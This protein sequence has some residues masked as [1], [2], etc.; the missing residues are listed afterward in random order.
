M[1]FFKK[2]DFERS[3]KI[4]KKIR[5]NFFGIFFF[6][7][8]SCNDHDAIENISK[9][10]FTFNGFYAFLLSNKCILDTGDKKKIIFSDID[11][12]SYT[13]YIYVDK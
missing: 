5:K 12:R 2:I 8:I 6:E 4:N 11:R 3:Y 9:I 7:K 13:I 10:L 1:I